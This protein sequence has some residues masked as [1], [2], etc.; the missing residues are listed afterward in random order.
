MLETQAE[1]KLAEL[2]REARELANRVREIEDAVYDLKTV[3]QGY[4]IR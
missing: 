2:S 3:N 4:A 1:A